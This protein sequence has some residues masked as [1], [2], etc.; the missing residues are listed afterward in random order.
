MK[1]LHEML[2]ARMHKNTEQVSRQMYNQT[3]LMQRH[4]HAQFEKT[5][6][7]IEQNTREITKVES[8]GQQMMSFTEQL[9]SLERTLKNP[10][11]R[12]MVGEVA[13]EQIIAN[14]LPPDAYATQHVFRSGIRA[15]AII[16]LRDGNSI[17]VDAKFSLENYTKLLEGEN[18]E[19]AERQLRK[20][21][22]ERIQETAKY[23]LPDEG[24]L[25]FAFMFIPSE[26]LYYDLLTHT[27]GGGTKNMLEQA[28]NEHRVIIV[29]PTTLLAYLQTVSLGLRSLRIEQHVQDVIADVRTL[30]RH[31]MEHGK[32]MKGIGRALSIAVNHY[33]KAEQQHGL[34][35]KDIQSIS[36]DGG[37][38]VRES[39]DR[40]QSLEKSA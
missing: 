32:S 35:D 14:T 23:I 30:H 18:K 25:D 12:G 10:Q 31:V 38:Y 28:F 9:Q 13:L 16:F 21:I 33:N 39:L 11:R 40:P 15:D 5:M 3:E 19:D 37:E 1:D 27:I 17:S 22:K 2:D 29:S 24:T 4:V 34:I 8:A 6:K 36:G 26:S 20:D 7:V